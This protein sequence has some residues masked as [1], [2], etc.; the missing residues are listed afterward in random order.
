V[1]TRDKVG[2]TRRSG[3][4]WRR[5]GNGADD[6]QLLHAGSEN[7]LVGVAADARVRYV[8][9]ASEFETG[10]KITHKSQRLH[11]AFPYLTAI[12][13]SPRSFAIPGLEDAARVLCWL[14]C[15]STSVQERIRPIAPL[16]KPPRTRLTLST[17]HP[18]V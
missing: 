6:E 17:R 7:V 18:A 3:L 8:Y 11:G 5:S 10:S 14:C 4:N 16:G 1:D 12:P 9:V 15:V 2:G 13:L